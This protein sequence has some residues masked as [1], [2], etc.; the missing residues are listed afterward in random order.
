M[1]VILSLI[2]KLIMPSVGV[3]L[4]FFCHVEILGMGL[5]AEGNQNEQPPWVEVKMNG[6]KRSADL[7]QPDQ[8]R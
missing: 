2:R 4:I 1:V 5:T 6:G 7:N 3:V 8:R